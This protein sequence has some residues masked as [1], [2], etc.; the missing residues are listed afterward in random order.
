MHKAAT[1]IRMAIKPIGPKDSTLAR[2]KIKELPQ[3]AASKINKSA[4]ILIILFRVDNTL[5]EKLEK[6]KGSKV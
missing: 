3:I 2:M 4:L 1:M 5:I 6:M